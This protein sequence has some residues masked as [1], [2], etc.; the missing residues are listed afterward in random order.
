MRLLD[1]L[2]KTKQW[3]LVFH[4]LAADVLQPQLRHRKRRLQELG[5]T[6][7]LNC[8]DFSYRLVERKSA[9]VLLGCHLWRSEFDEREMEEHLTVKNVSD[10]I[11]KR[12][13]LWI[14]WRT[15]NSN[16]QLYVFFSS[17]FQLANL[18]RVSPRNPF[19]KIC[20]GCIGERC[21]VNLILSGSWLR[22]CVS[23]FNTVGC[24]PRVSM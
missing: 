10:V 20:Q 2:I 4:N 22:I 7:G 5:G 12:A 14:F 8:S 3:K 13:C 11:E 9:V 21:N 17:C 23:K 19:L 15:R 1:L 16:L 24:S 6:I 18:F